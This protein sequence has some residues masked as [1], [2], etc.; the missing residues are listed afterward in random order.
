MSSEQTVIK[1]PPPDRNYIHALSVSHT[2]AGLFYTESDVWGRTTFHRDPH[3]YW[4]M[5]FYHKPEP[6]AWNPDAPPLVD[7]RPYEVVHKHW[8]LY[9]AQR[10]TYAPPPVK[11]SFIDKP[12]DQ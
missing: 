5:R 6:P 2:E 11:S 7:V 9:H 1:G 4:E 3:G 10:S 12:A 8:H